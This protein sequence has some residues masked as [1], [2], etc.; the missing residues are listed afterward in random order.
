MT[1]AVIVQ[2]NEGRPRRHNFT[3]RPRSSGTVAQRP[4]AARSTFSRATRLKVMFIDAMHSISD[5]VAD[6]G[7]PATLELSRAGTLHGAD[8][9]PTPCGP[10]SR[11]RNRRV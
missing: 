3:G 10:I 4:A 2:K 6:V 9:S 1:I 7:A 5:H 11:G 8:F